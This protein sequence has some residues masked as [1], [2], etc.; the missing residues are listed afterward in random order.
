MAAD[1]A[2]ALQAAARRRHDEARRRAVEALRRLSTTGGPVSL[3]AVAE[4]AGV[5]R[6]WLYRQADLRPA[7]DSLRRSPSRAVRPARPAAERATAE[8]LRQQLE[9]LRA[10]ESE[11][12]AENHRLREAIARKLG[13]DRA[14]AGR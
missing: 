5:S 4:A 2:L 10:L 12:R 3:A 8:S 14:G 1:R 7:I 13:E 11:L 9:A 6:A